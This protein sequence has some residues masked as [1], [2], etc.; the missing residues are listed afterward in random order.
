MLKVTLKDKKIIGSRSWSFHSFK[1]DEA[2]D[3]AMTEIEEMYQQ[4]RTVKA[5]KK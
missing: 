4:W 3:K 2:R 5:V 1:N